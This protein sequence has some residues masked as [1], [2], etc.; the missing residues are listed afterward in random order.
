MNIHFSFKN[1]L[2]FTIVV[3]LLM[4]SFLAWDYFHEGVPTHYILHNDEYPGFSNWWGAI[5]IPLITWGLLYLV[6]LRVL[7]EKPKNISA[8]IAYGFIGFLLYGI[9]SSILFMM[10]FETILLYMTVALIVSAFFIPI[11]RPECLLGYI[12]AM[13]YVFGAILP[14]LFGIIFWTLY[15]I[16]YKLPRIILQYINKKKYNSA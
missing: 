16:A 12:L 9:V 1:R 11:Y 8:S 14:L 4:W 7:K 5:T 13:T 2:L 6:Q 10:G 15:I 3:S